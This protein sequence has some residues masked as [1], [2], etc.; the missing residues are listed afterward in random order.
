[1]R[2]YIMALALGA[3]LTAGAQSQQLSPECTATCSEAGMSTGIQLLGICSA[4]VEYGSKAKPEVKAAC[5]QCLK[6]ACRGGE[7]PE[8]ALITFPPAGTEIGASTIFKWTKGRNMKKYRLLVGWSR[9]SDEL[10][11]GELTTDQSPVVKIPANKAGQPIYAWLSSFDGQKW[12]TTQPV[13]FATQGAAGLLDIQ[14]PPASPKPGDKTLNDYF[15]LPPSIIQPPPASSGPDISGS[16]TTPEGSTMV[17]M[18][19]SGKGYSGEFRFAQQGVS[20]SMY[21]E[22]DGRQFAGRYETRNAQ[23]GLISRG[24]Q[25]LIPQSDRWYAPWV[26]EQGQQGFWILVRAR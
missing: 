1:M 20:G 8:A 4:P 18:L 11:E 25:W 7:Q 10:Y 5:D 13:K 12:L 16:W 6:E 2:H 9:G 17:H 19:R 26:D 15:G 23:G 21:V 14:M 22:W 24:A 3:I